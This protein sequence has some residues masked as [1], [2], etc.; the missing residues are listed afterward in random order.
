MG[1]QYQ[2]LSFASYGKQKTFS[3]SKC[4]ES[5]EHAEEYKNHQVIA[6]SVDWISTAS[7][8]PQVAPELV[9]V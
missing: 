5:K 3:T 8:V 6:T 7:L 9:C 1:K 4:Q 2:Y